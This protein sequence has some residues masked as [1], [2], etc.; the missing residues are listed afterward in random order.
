MDE[1]DDPLDWEEW[2]GKGHFIHHMIAG[3]CAGVV[4]HTCMFPVDTIKVSY[5][6][7]MRHKNVDTSV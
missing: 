4:E 3:S 7:Y 2:D 6:S 5:M 1:E